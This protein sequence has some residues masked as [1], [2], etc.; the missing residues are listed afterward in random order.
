MA[1][2]TD[3]EDMI[4][5]MA[6]GDRHAL[7]ALY[8]ATSAKLFGIALRVLDDRSEAEDALQEIYVKLWH[9]ADRYRSNGLSP[10]TWL[11]TVTRNHAIDRLRARRGRATAPIEAV[12]ELADGAPNPEESA[13]AASMRGRIGAC[14][15]T[16]PPD[17]AEAIC[18]AYLGGEAYA[19]LAERYRVPLNTIR[20]WLR[21]GLLTLRE[22][23][24]S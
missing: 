11:I 7:S 3:I 4:A 20:T 18:R 16:L 24:G 13:L 9:N 1:S 19:D 8:A 22:C 14:L 23:I 2:L 17:R 21:R 15:Q 6:I 10:M 5:R 12:S